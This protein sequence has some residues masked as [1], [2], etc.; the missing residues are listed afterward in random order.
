MNIYLDLFVTFAKIGALT[1][2]G[3]IAMLPMLEKELVKK[4]QWV[5]QE[6]ILDYFAIGQCTPGIIAVNT[7]TF[8]G[9][10]KRG[11]VGGIVATLGLIFPSIVV[12]D[13]IAALLF[14]FADIP[15]VKNAFAGI[16]VA[17]CVLVLNAFVKLVKRSVVD[18]LTAI[19]LLAVMLF[20]ILTDI[21]PAIFVLIAALIGLAAKNFLPNEKIEVDGE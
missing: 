9:E 2:G 17:V 6:E 4:K 5:T 11:V 14:N 19:I 3:G 1:F 18:V 20:S 16:R 12:I 8:V 15:V 10:K 7:A 13:I 21:S